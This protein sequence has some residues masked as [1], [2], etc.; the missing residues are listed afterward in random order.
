MPCIR[1]VRGVWYLHHYL[2]PGAGF[3]FWP[4]IWALMFAGKDHGCFHCFSRTPG[5]AQPDRKRSSTLIWKNPSLKVMERGRLS[6]CYYGNMFKRERVTRLLFLPAPHRKIRMRPPPSQWVE[7]SRKVHNTMAKQ[8]ATA[9]RR[10]RKED[11]DELLI[12]KEIIVLVR[13]RMKC[14]IF[15]WIKRLQRTDTETN[16]KIKSFSSLLTI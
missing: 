16:D 9:P 8:Q 11:N 3:T 14:W 7:W 2:V 12:V 10:C 1:F 5:T 6:A 15:S 13:P 4:I